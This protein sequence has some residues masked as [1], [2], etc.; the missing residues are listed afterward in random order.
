MKG[1]LVILAA[2]ASSG[3]SSFLPLLVVAGLMG[4]MYFMVIRPQSRR[5][6]EM[7]ELQSSVDVGAAV[8]TIGGLHAT[9]VE[10]DEETVTL[11]VAP[12]VHCRYARGAIGKILPAD[13]DDD[14]ASEAA[15]DDP[16]EL[17]EEPGPSPDSKARSDGA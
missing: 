11:A 8:I 3:G 2:P 4:L 1:P 16:L 9:V 5:R 13:A 6:K 17:T 10:V 12:G 14:S 7:Q 15:D